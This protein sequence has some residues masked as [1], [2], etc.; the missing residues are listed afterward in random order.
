V[1]RATRE[2]VPGPEGNIVALYFA[3]LARKVHGYA[4]ELLGARALERGGDHDWPVHYLESFKWG[5]GGGTLE[6]RRNAIGE[7]ML[8]LPKGPQAK[9]AK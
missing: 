7:R 2:A 6:I 1:S 5:I 9:D 3:E 4:Y 8:G